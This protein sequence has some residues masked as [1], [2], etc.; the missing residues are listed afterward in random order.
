MGKKY[1]VVTI[2]LDTFRE[3]CL[4]NDNVIMPNLKNFVFNRCMNFTQ[5]IPEALPTIPVRR[6]MFT[7]QRYFPHNVENIWDGNVFQIKES[8]NNVNKI[9]NLGWDAIPENCMTIA[10]VMK[11][12]NY[13][14]VCVMN[15]H[16]INKRP[17]IKGFNRVHNFCSLDSITELD[18]DYFVDSCIAETEPDRNKI[19]WFLQNNPWLLNEDCKLEDTDEYRMFQM[20]IAELK[21]KNVHTPLYLHLDYFSLHQPYY[22]PKKYIEMYENA[23]YEGIMDFNPGNRWFGVEYPT[24]FYS[25]ECEEDI[26][27]RYYAQCTMFDDLFGEFIKNLEEMN[28]LDD[29][30]ILIYSDHGICLG[31]YKLQAKPNNYNTPYVVKNIAAMYVPGWVA[32]TND[33][34]FYNYDVMATLFRNVLGENLP[35]GWYGKNVILD[36]EYDYVVG[37]YFQ[38]LYYYDKKYLY[39][40]SKDRTTQCLWDMENKK[41]I[42]V[43]LNE[44]MV[45]EFYG[46]IM[47]DGGYDLPDLI[48]DERFKD[49]NE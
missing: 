4:Y 3:E 23:P 24:K 38:Y 5:I 20:A 49:V 35:E 11:E 30:I 22:T 8:L 44:I 9:P 15:T 28:R 13:N 29:T 25:E 17:F 27:N 32:E 39:S 2:F 6:S 26:R 21:Y 12:R 14:T 48:V 45:D 42:P 31:E 36:R 1:N 41:F 18:V 19:K 7:C 34:L 10:E 16:P 43:E 37:N 46:R 47:E 33:K 40:T